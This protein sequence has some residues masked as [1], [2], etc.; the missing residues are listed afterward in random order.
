MKRTERKT[1]ATPCMHM[2]ASEYTPV[3]SELEF[4]ELGS[5]W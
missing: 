2:P 5:V 1:P 4:V 3:E